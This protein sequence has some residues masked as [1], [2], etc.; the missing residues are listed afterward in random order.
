MIRL[1]T[2]TLLVY[3]TICSAQTTETNYYQFRERAGKVSK[4][5]S[6]YTETITTFADGQKN[7]VLTA[8][9][10]GDTLESYKNN[11]P[12]GKWLVLKPATNKMMPLDYNFTVAYGDPKKKR[13][14]SALFFKTKSAFPLADN[15]SLKY[16]A[17][18]LA[19]GEKSMDIFVQRNIC[20]PQKAI[21]REIQG[22]VNVRFVVNEDASISDIEVINGVNIL[23]DKEAMRLV[24]LLRFSN[25]AMVNGA[26]KKMLLVLP[27]NFKLEY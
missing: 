7:A 16:I 6:T 21:D 1:L 3:T 10:T 18:K 12:V 24:R 4:N 8:T 13:P 15:D 17:P 20:Y 27:V 11:E 22:R 25:G 5:R 26:R 9:K 19:S 23:L 14:D 2:F